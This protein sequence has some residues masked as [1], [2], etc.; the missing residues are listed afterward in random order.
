MWHETREKITNWI[1]WIWGSLKGGQPLERIG[2][3]TQNNKK[4]QATGHSSQ[5]CQKQLKAEG[6]PL[7]NNWTLI[8]I[9]RK[10]ILEVARN[11]YW[12][13]RVVQVITQPLYYHSLHRFL[14]ETQTS[15]WVI[16][17]KLVVSIRG[18]TTVVWNPP[19]ARITRD[20]NRQF[21]TLVKEERSLSIHS[22]KR[23][24]TMNQRDRT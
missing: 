6:S 17:N 14:Y 7:A 18:A 15:Y 16:W 13:V 19:G 2:T 5:S 3:H 4:L 12:L 9:N 23:I 21:T 1:R 10:I 24:R 11:V 22:S 8:F 20:K